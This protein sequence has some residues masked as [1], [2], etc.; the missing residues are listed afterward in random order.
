MAPELVFYNSDEEYR[1]HY[2]RIYCRG[3]IITQDNI[4]V[5][6]KPDRFNHAFYVP[7]KRKGMKTQFSHER[8]QRIDWIK[9]TLEAPDSSLLFGWNN[10]TKETDW[11]RRVSVRY[12]DYIVVIELSRSKAGVIKGNFI[13]AFPATGSMDSI[14]SNPE[15]T[16]ELWLE[17]NQ[18]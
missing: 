4:R 9:A 1:Q 2:K 10:T 7:Q 3:K 17:K 6:F 18:V 11:N 5:Y 14:N 16:L 13:T 15:W 12:D 8:A